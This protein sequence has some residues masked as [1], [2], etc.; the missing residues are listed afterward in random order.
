MIACAFAG[1]M[2]DSATSSSL[3]AVLRLSAATAS[4]EAQANASAIRQRNM[5][6]SFEVDGL[7][8]PRAVWLTTR[9]MRSRTELTK[10]R[11]RP[12]SDFRRNAGRPLPPTAFARRSRLREDG[13]D[14]PA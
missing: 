4:C 10:G 3:L 1:P 5:A 13:R 6:F 2:P 9:R 8:A 14:P 11:D 12:K 7:V